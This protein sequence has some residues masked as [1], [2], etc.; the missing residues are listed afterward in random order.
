MGQVIGESSPKAEVPQNRAIDPQDLMAT[1]F[2]VMGLNRELAYIDPAGR[3]TPMITSGRV[4]AEL[5]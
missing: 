3:P 4:I 5:V 1:V 2:E